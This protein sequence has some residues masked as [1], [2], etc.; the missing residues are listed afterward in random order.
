MG[1]DLTETSDNHDSFV[2]FDT[3]LN[4]SYRKLLDRSLIEITMW[5]FTVNCKKNKKH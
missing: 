4:L 1:K 2:F 5:L 3:E